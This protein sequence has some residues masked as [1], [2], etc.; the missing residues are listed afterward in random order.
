[1]TSRDEPAT[2]I[3]E[4][5]DLRD[6]DVL[7]VTE[8]VEAARI[9]LVTTVADDGR[10]V[11]R[12]LAVQSR[13]FD[14]DLFFFTQDPSSKT[15]QVRVNDHV[16]VAFQADHGYVSISGTATVSKDPEMIDRLWNGAAAAWFEN[17]RE[18]PSVALLQVHAESAE[19]WS[20]DSPAVV[21]AL[22]YA[23]A[24]V[25]GE[26]PDLGHNATVELDG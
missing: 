14:G 12:P 15:S 7:R 9:A 5:D 16:N 2:S 25:T 26:R 18:D 13:P 11:S 22:K 24:R 20:V 17:G 1:M 8:L 4:S 6:P 21:T 3:T 10:L 19:F 23:K